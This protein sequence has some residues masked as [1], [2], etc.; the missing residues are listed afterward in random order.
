MTGFRWW[1]GVLPLWAPV[2]LAAQTVDSSGNAVKLSGFF[3]VVLRV[4]RPE[5]RVEHSN[6]DDFGNPGGLGPTQVT[7]G[8][9]LSYLF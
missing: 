1:A 2:A 7:V 9:A 5:L 4:V 6:R 3:K 8:R